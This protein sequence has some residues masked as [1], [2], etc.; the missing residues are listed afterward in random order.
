MFPYFWTGKAPGVPVGVAP[1]DAEHPEGARSKP[2]EHD[3]HCQRSPNE[4]VRARCAYLP[5]HPCQVIHPLLQTGNSSERY[6]VSAFQL[7]LLWRLKMNS[8]HHTSSDPQRPSRHML[9]M[10]LPGY[11]SAFSLYT[12]NRLLWGDSALNM[13]FWLQSASYGC[14]MVYQERADFDLT[15]LASRR[16]QK[17]HIDSCWMLPSDSKQGWASRQ[18][19]GSALQAFLSQ[20][21]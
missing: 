20:R 15:N 9:D 4:V 11:T 2:R 14:F 19:S 18:G 10:V 16:Y 17:T 6:L 3:H 1:S 21:H 8:S 5:R 12:P 13:P 7:N